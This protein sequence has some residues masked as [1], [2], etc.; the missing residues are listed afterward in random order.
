[1]S[2]SLGNAWLPVN[3][4]YQN[5]AYNAL[6]WESIFTLGLNAA[7]STNYIEKCFK[8]KLLRIKFPIKNSTEAYL[9][10]PQEW[11]WGS[12]DLSYLKYNAALVWE[13]S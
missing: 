8:Q 5:T 2:N 10:L 6:K 13:S 9:Y 1:M 4:N 7:K 11:R 12:K 3:F